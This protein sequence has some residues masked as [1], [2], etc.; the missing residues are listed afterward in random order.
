MWLTTCYF[1]ISCEWYYKY[2]NKQFDN[3]VQRQ[4]LFALVR[5]SY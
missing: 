5:I 1:P 3:T 2:I 4:Q